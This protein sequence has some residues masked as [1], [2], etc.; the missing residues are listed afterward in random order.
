MSGPSR[1]QA[2]VELALVLPVVAVLL[3][4]VLQVGLLARDRVL[5]VH[6]ARVAARAVAVEP[7]VAAARQALRQVGDDRFRVVLSGE[8]TPGGTATVTVT[9]R[10][11]ALPIIGRVL[12]GAEVSERLS[13]RVEGP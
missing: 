6:A 4:L 12:G 11:T 8:L 5:A 9:A 10:P 7:D 3:L 2:T 1:G 13:V